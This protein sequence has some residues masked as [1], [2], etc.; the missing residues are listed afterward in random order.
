MNLCSL[1]CEAGFVSS[2]WCAYVDE[3]SKY[4]L[5]LSSFAFLMVVKSF[6]QTSG[7]Y[8]W[9]FFKSKSC[10]KVLAFRLCSPK[11]LRAKL[12]R[13]NVQLEW[14]L[15]GMFVR[16]LSK[17]EKEWVVLCC[18]WLEK[19][20]G[21][22]IDFCCS[23]STFRMHWCANNV[24]LCERKYLIVLNSRFALSHLYV[25]QTMLSCRFVHFNCLL[26]AKTS[27]YSVLLIARLTD[28]R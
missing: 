15:S 21:F 28:Y 22:G 11:C 5:Y 3:Q 8:Y 12:R 4:V 6:K 25:M 1:F 13:S 20:Y 9:I 19:C 10:M 26:V 16:A 7:F 14:R 24:V 2:S 18:H 17:C 23:P 27:F